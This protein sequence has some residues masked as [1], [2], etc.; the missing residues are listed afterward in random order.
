M[1]NSEHEEGSNK[2]ITYVYI[3]DEEI[4][5]FLIK[6]GAYMS[7]VQYFDR[8]VGYIIEIANEDFIVVDEIGIG[9]MEEMEDNL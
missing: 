8:G 3:P 6:E 9:H 7:T 1:N 2:I 5:G 4:H